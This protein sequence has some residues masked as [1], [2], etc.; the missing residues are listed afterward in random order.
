M[1]SPRGILS[2]SYHHIGDEYTGFKLESAS[3][4]SNRTDLSLD[5]RDIIVADQWVVLGKIGE[6]S[7]GEV[8]EARDINTGRHFA[9]KRE[10]LKMKHPQLKFENIMYDVLAGGVGIPQCH[11]YGQFDGFDCIVM[12]LLGPNL[13]QVRQNVSMMELDIAIDLTCQMLSIVEHIHNRGVIVRDIKPDNFLFPASCHLPEPEMVE[14][15]DEF[16]MPV[17]TYKKSTCRQVFEE[18]WGLSRP[19]LYAVDF[20]LA[21]YWR[22]PDTGKPYPDTKKHTKSKTGTARYASINV[23]RG[24]SHS[25]RDDVESIGYILLD[26][27]LGTLPWAGVH[28]KTSKAGW[29][30]MRQLKVDTFMSDLCAGL[31]EGILRFVEYPRSLRFADQP[32]YEKMRQFLQGSLPGG[33]YSDLVK[34]PFGGKTESTDIYDHVQH[35]EKP[36]QY[37]NKHRKQADEHQGMFTMDDDGNN[38]VIH[39]LAN[40]K[41]VDSTQQ[42]QRK[43]S[44]TSQSSLHKLLKRNKAKKVGWNTHKHAQVP[45]NPKTDWSTGGGKDEPGT[46]ALSKSWGDDQPQEAMWGVPPIDSVVNNEWN[47]KVKNGESGNINDDWNTKIDVQDEENGNGINSGWHSENKLQDH[48]NKMNDKSNK[49]DE[50]GFGNKHH[51]RNDKWDSGWPQPLSPHKKDTITSTNDPLKSTWRSRYN[52]GT[53]ISQNQQQQNQQ[54]HQKKRSPWKNVSNEA[55]MQWQVSSAKDI[56]PSRQRHHSQPHRRYQHPSSTK[57]TNRCNENLTTQQQRLHQ[58][59][60]KYNNNNKKEN[61]NQEEVM[62]DGWRRK[63]NSLDWYQ[64]GQRSDE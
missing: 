49:W 43:N 8:F 6:G 35:E 28:A 21:C 60:S 1:T 44:T 4:E 14:S 33:P 3:Y 61:N 22:D 38:D 26:L 51:Q 7:F 63:P 29:D 53:T 50:S 5:S 48:N 9:I 42:R 58:Q 2:S 37:H 30:R 32:D 34:S 52:D 12:D 15:S 20:G 24:K 56:P 31:P 10:T 55:P 11:W 46:S 59:T 40:T 57:N 47:I 19:T 64:K 54:H 41:L 18:Q 39:Q 25:R 16:S 27:L 36:Y 45:W 23:H 17:T 13:S 62:I